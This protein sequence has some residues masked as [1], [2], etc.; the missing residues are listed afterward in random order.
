[1]TTAAA[2][3]LL[4]LV[5]YGLRAA[6]LLVTGDNATIQRVANPLTAAILASLVVTT[7]IARGTDFAIDARVVGLVVAIVAALRGAPLVVT[8]AL[9][10]GSTALVRLVTG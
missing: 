3:A 7:T 5:T 9:A 4:A 8:L 1:M 2:I 6:G 10:V